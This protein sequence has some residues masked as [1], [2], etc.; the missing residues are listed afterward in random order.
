MGTCYAIMGENMFKVIEVNVTRAFDVSSI[1][2][3]VEK[4]INDHRGAVAAVLSAA[5][6][7]RIYIYTSLLPEVGYP[8][9]SASYLKKTE[10]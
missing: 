2:T 10:P 8:N 7:E 4:C 3:T 5:Q 6:R 1:I 9:I